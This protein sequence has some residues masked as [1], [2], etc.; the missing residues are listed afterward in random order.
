MATKIKGNISL[1][2][3][4]TYGITSAQLYWERMAAML[5]RLPFLPFPRFCMGF[6]YVDDFIFLVPQNHLHDTAYPAM[7]LLLAAGCPI[8]CKKTVIGTSNIWLGYQISSTTGTAC[9]TPTKQAAM[10]ARRVRKN[11]SLTETTTPPVPGS[12]LAGIT[13]HPSPT[14]VVAL[15]TGQVDWCE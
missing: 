10:S 11:D 2:T 14:T 8:S 1:S 12:H 4:G 6:E 15:G 3:C 5:L 13:Q 7:M 9:L